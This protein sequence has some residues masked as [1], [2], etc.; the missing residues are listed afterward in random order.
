MVLGIY[1]GSK[2]KDLIYMFYFDV[3]ELWQIQGSI[4]IASQ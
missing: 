1:G 3:Y 2:M 4:V